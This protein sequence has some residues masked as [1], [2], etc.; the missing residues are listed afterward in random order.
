MRIVGHFALS[1]LA[2]DQDLDCRLSTKANAFYFG[3]W[4]YFRK[5]IL[6]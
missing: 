4:S 5:F 3:F 2:N 1:I 6:C